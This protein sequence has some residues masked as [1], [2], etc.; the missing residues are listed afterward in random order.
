MKSAFVLTTI[1]LLISGCLPDPLPVNDVPTPA[2]TIVIGSQNLPDEFLVISVSENFTALEGGRQSDL[3]SLVQDFLID[4]LAMFINVLG[5]RYLM[6][7][8]SVSGIYFADDIP[9]ISGAA[10]TLSTSNPFNDRPTTATTINMPF[11]GFDSLSLSIERTPFDTLMYVDMRIDDPLGPNWY[12]MNVQT[13]GD[14]YNIGDRPFTELLSDENF[15]GELFQYSF[16]VFFKDYSQGDTVLVSMTNINK[17]YYDFL[18]LRNDQ[19]YLL[20]DGLGEPINYP[21][22]VQNGLGYFHMHIPDARLLIPTE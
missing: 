9:N 3:D 16:K 15:D 11:I 17:G 13:F 2:K 8:D 21:T 20:L 5:E 12:M 6:N 7:Y 10:Y 14:E 18:Q 19:R 1:C 22:N 4:S